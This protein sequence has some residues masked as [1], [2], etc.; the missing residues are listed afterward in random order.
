[1]KVEQGNIAIVTIDG[2]FKRILKDGYNWVWSHEDIV[3]YNKSEIYG[4]NKYFNL[5]I[6]NTEINKLIKTMKV[7]DSELVVVYNEG[8]FD[9]ILVPGQYFYW[10]NTEN[11][12]FTKVDL[13]KIEITE[14][15][16]RTVLLNATMLKYVR[17]FEVGSSEKGLLFVDGKFHSELNQGSYYYWRNTIS[18]E[19]KKI[20]IRQTQLELSGQEILTKDKAA[21]RINFYAQYKITDIESALLKTKDYEKQLYILIQLALRAFVGTQTLD[22]LL[23]NKEAVSEYVLDALK[24]KVKSIGVQ[25]LG[26]GLRDIILPGEMKEIMNRVLIAQKQAQAN[27]IMRREET[28]STRSM[29]NTAKL[30]EDNEMLFKLKEMEYVEKIA[31][32]I[33]EVTVSGNGRVMDQLK[34]MFAK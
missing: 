31:E 14:D 25:L 33:G 23:D 19:L 32:R 16:K 27:V 1:M 3:T 12:T 6:K 11:Y 21:L 7:S 15:I 34:G 24:M 28:A 9:R 29:L 10:K 4:V 8:L 2:N 5:V 26:A 17:K 22:E 30:M 20:D 18:I 13:G